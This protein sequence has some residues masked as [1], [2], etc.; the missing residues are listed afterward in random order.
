MKSRILTVSVVLTFAVSTLQLSEAA[1]TARAGATCSKKGAIQI[2][3]T[4]K[5]TCTAVGKKL[6]W[7][8]GV[9]QTEKPQVATPL[10][11]PSSK[12][13]QPEV[14]DTKSYGWS[15]R[16]SN[17]G[18]LERKGGPVT[19]WSSE[20]KRSGQLLDSVR[21]NAFK[22][23]TEYSKVAN[24]GAAQINFAFG[25][26]VEASAEAAYRAYFNASLRFFESRIPTGTKLNVLVVTEKDDAFTEASLNKFID[27]PNQ[28]RETF[29]RN[30]PWIHQFDTLGKQSSGGG[31]V[32]SFG[33]GKPLLYFGYICSCFNSEDLLMYNVG[34]EMTHYFQFATT[35]SVRKQNFIGNYPN[36]VEGRI[37]IPNSLMEG[38]A[39]TLGSA[40][41]VPYVGWYSDMMD[42]HLGRYKRAGKVK[43][44]GTLDEAVTLMKATRSWDLESVGLGELNYA[45]G[46]LIWEYYISKYGMLSYINLF[47]NIEKYG[48]IESAIQKTEK[49]SEEDFYRDA[50]QYVMKAFN[51]VTS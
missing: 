43:S 5:F 42:W 14:I 28:A 25:P 31:S 39:N 18:I 23:I 38:S 10:V 33:P 4:K 12:P 49:I 37:Y 21:I 35:P 24:K 13:S 44:I 3:G 11:S 32:G 15:F 6:L 36:W 20:A 47:D 41:L 34:H 22:E 1:T 27:D 50:A 29:Q 26:N 17:L 16:I 2:V 40:I 7:N 8:K 45:L 9:A 46:Q 30:K 48:D 51:A 19:N